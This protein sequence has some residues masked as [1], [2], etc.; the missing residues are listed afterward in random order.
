MKRIPNLRGLLPPLLAALLVGC[1]QAFLDTD[2]V[3]RAA[4][5]ATLDGPRPGPTAPHLPAEPE[6]DDPLDPRQI[7]SVSTV[8]NPEA[9]R[10][11]ICLAECICLALE[12][13]RT[14][15]F[16]DRP[17]AE[18]RSSVSGLQA[19]APASNFT[20]SIRVFAY[21][22]AIVA[23]D[24]EQALSR[25]DV[26]WRT[27]A[28]WNRVGEPF[29]FEPA[30]LPVVGVLDNNQ[31]DVV[32]FRTELL[33]PLPTGGVAGITFRT[34]YERAELP[35]LSPILN[36]AYQPGVELSFEQPLLQ[37]SGVLMNQLRQTFP[38]SLLHPLPSSAVPPE[39]RT[40]GIL[41]ARIAREEAQLDFERRV[42]ALLFAVE[43]AYWD[44]YCA[45]WDLYS[46]ENGL[47]QAFVVWQ[48]VNGRLR[49]GGATDADLA[50]V[51]EQYHFFRAQRLEALGRGSGGRPG[52][53]EAERRLR[54]V[55]GLPA[56]DGC[57]LVPTDE[58]VHI[59]VELDWAAAV[60][61]AREQRP[62]LRQ[63]K[64]EVQA[65][66]LA[67][68][69]AGDYLWP[70]LR[71]LSR[72]G[73]NGLGPDLGGGFRN[74]TQDPFPSWQV[75]LQL[76]VPIGYRAA[77]AEVGRAR[78]VLAQRFAFL[79]DQEAKTVLSLQRSYRDVVQFREEMAI[80]RSQRAAAA[81]QVKVRFE[82]FKAGGNESV[83][84]LLR[85]QRNWA[86]SL[87]EEQLAVCRY[88]IALADFERQKGT[89]MRYHNVA[90]L[91]GE[92]PG[93]LETHASRHIRDLNAA[94]VQIGHAAA[95]AGSAASATKASSLEQL[96][97][98]P[99]TSLRS[100]LEPDQ[101]LPAIPP[102]PQTTRD[103]G[104]G[105]PVAIGMKE[106]G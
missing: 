85:A 66:Q 27:R 61:A 78:L 90:M 40:P 88:N 81:L 76:Q 41:L 102:I 74:L 51:E 73:L 98:P 80:R 71:F 21:D 20:D 24:I 93:P 33:K 106:Q 65:A 84:L 34:D 87:R 13:G 38:A 42:H 91:E 46:R 86:D 99:R 11:P 9:P 19:M 60:A 63:V 50:Q 96:L 8:A 83:D 39:G 53:L 104:L 29:G 31:I 58:P 3:K 14:G 25:F 2:P 7:G 23:T 59:P 37:G 52:V 97:E 94:A 67:L 64:Q 28:D 18:R 10:R 68:T 75:G 62:E 4:C 70:D 95:P 44:L 89:I 26:L 79:R 100:Y 22:P 49:A 72:Y 55:V 16:F 48:H 36:P 43:E 54:Y 17:D 15:E 105:P 101:D 1:Q 82:R 57:R 77:N 12:H 6:G 45:Y 35:F 30:Q 103:S 56:E 92:A 5:E 32:G 69:R 47:R